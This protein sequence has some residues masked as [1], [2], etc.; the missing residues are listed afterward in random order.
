MHV[1]SKQIGGPR[2]GNIDNGE[3]ER[4]GDYPRQ[5]FTMLAAT[6]ARLTTIAAHEKRSRWRVLDDC[7]NLYFD[8]MTAKNRRAVAKVP[9]RAMRR[10]RARPL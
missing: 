6:N 9:P 10:S 4:V 5:T 7:I 2:R 1:E 8:Q 3:P